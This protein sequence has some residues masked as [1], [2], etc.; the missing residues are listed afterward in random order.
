MRMKRQ[1]LGGTS[2]GKQMVKQIYVCMRGTGRRIRETESQSLKQ[3]EGN[4][5]KDAGRVAKKKQMHCLTTRSE[6]SKSCTTQAIGPG[7]YN[8]SRS[9]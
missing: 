8:R 4:R 7:H 9:I 5:L 1:N 3:E 6:P 2:T